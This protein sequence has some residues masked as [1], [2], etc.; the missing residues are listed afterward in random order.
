MFVDEGFGTLDEN[1]LEQAMK[2]LIELTKGERLVGIIS[3]VNE[4][5]SRVD[6][7]ITVRKSKE[8]GSN[9]KVMV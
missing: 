9:A 4:L 3:H 2:A 8:G 6:K 1:S 7:Q 5:K